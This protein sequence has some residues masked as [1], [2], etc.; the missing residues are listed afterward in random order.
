[1]FN[2]GTYLKGFSTH[3]L[4]DRNLFNDFRHMQNEELVK[5]NDDFMDILS[6]VVPFSDTWNNMADVQKAYF[7]SWLALNANILSSM[8]SFR[9]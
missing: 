9:K 4:F 2:I 8:D 1:M 7:N 6:K 3:K 5:W